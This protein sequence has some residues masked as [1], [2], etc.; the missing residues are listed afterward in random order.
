MTTLAC[1]YS[2]DLD[3]DLVG[4]ILAKMKQQHMLRIE[5]YSNKVIKL[6]DEAF[7]LLPYPMVDNK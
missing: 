1:T 7:Q 3:Y 5:A 6:E 2:G 4:G